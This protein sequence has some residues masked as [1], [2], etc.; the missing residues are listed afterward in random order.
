MFISLCAGGMYHRSNRESVYIWLCALM[1]LVVLFDI[2]L[3]SDD[4][5]ELEAFFAVDLFPGGLWNAVLST[6]EI[7]GSALGLFL[8]SQ[9]TWHCKP[10]DDNDAE[11]F[12]KTLKV[13]HYQLGTYIIVIDSS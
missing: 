10:L 12:K 13:F 6:V 7:G 2:N 4:N 11:L 9:R 3:F 5:L 8:R 1:C